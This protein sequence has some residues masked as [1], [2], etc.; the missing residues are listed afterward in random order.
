M[1][2]LVTI[3]DKLAEQVQPGVPAAKE[4]LQRVLL[5][6]AAAALY[7]VGKLTKTQVMLLLGF[8]ERED[9]YTFLH[10]HH[11]PMTTLDALER[12]R[13]ASERLGF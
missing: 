13:A 10:T 8:E 12:D 11:I 1:E 9:F 5:E 7:R 4:A 3:P 6:E 2:I